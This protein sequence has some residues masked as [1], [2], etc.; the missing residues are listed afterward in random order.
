MTSR[1]LIALSVV[2]TAFLGLT[3][4]T[5]DKAFQE[6]ARTAVK[7]RLQGRVLALIAAAEVKMNGSIFIPDVLPIV[8]FNQPRSGLYGQISNNKGE[9]LWKSPSLDEKSLPVVK[10]STSTEIKFEKVRH[11]NEELFSY[12]FGVSWDLSNKVHIYTVSVAETLESYNKETIQFRNRLWMWLGGVAFVLLAVQG[13]ILSWS[14]R[15]LRRAA[16]EIEKIESGEQESLRGRYPKEL[17]GLTKNLNGLIESNQEHLERYRHSLSDLA[18]SLKT[19]L[20]LLQSTTETEDEIGP[21]RQIVAEQVDQ[22]KKIVDYQLQRA[23]TS[24]QKPLAQP[25]EI[26]TIASKISASLGKVYA[27]KNVNCE[28]IINDDLFFQGDESDLFE[29]LGNLIDNAFRWCQQLVRVSAE[30]GQDAEGEAQIF[31]SIE[32]DGPGIDEHMAARVLERGIRSDEKG[33]HGIG[34]A[35]VNNIVGAYQGNMEINRSELGGAWFLI[36]LPQSQIL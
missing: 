15:P 8:R 16:L 19:P 17:R 27:D 10:L 4:Y 36:S 20:A 3:G 35:V 28:I 11:E 30:L 29:L 33:G 14:L 24:G 32:D 31:I 13:T 26:K 6:S 2:L 7:D 18:H 22:M 23:A 25:V 5:L 9:K 34:L 21:F 12:N 1:L